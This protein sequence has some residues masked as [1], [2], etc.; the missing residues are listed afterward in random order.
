MK[1][2]MQVDYEGLD[3]Y[4]KNFTILLFKLIL[5]KK[6]VSNQNSIQ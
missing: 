3:F 4:E 1:V 2:R 5:M 6:T